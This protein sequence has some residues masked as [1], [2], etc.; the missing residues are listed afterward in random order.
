MVHSNYISKSG[1]PEVSHAGFPLGAVLLGRLKGGAGSPGKG[2][3]MDGLP[4]VTWPTM[5]LYHP[6]TF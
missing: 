5:S 6:S 4:L 3:R 2:V 1:P